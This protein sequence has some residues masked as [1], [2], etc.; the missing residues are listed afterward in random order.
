[1][2]QDDY[3]ILVGISCYGDNQNLCQLDGPENDV[4][5]M[6]D[7]LCDEQGIPKENIEKIVS[8]E[9]KPPPAPKDFPPLLQTYIDTFLGIMIGNDDNYIRRENG[10]LYLYFSGHGFSEKNDGSPHAS[11]YAGNARL[12]KGAYWNIFGTAFAKW[13]KNQG[14]F[15]EVVLIMD[16]CRDA[17]IIKAPTPPPLPIPV[18][19]GLSVDVKL[20]QLYA[21]PLGGKAQERPIPSRKNT[22]HGLLTHAFLEAV[23]YAPSDCGQ[24][25]TAEIKS[26]LENHWVALCDGQPADK[27]IIVIPDNAEIR[28][29]R[30]RG[31]APS[32]RFKLKT[33]NSGDTFEILN[34]KLETIAHVAVGDAE[35]EIKCNDDITLCPIENGIFTIPLF[36]SFYSVLGNTLRRSFETGGY[37]VEL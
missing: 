28:F 32:Q 15:H 27:P 11:L 3:A 24:V 12:K 37:N 23:K 25:T 19:I 22:V 18:D 14:L 29:K 4:N 10:R 26:Y 13:V 2:A 9:S 33:L 36:P 21:A 34:Q 1:M 17:E 8:V 16:C 31:A 7:W 30:S 35:V 6:Y 20:F 5:I